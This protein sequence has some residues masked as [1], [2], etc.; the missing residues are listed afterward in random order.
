[1]PPKQRSVFRY[2]L[3]LLLGKSANVRVLRELVVAGWP[4]LARGGGRAASRILSKRRSM[5]FLQNT[6][7]RRSRHPKTDSGAEV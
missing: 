2:L 7:C 4:C 6:M 3:D 5:T 1:M